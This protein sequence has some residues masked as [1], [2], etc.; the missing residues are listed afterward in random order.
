M[1]QRMQPVDPARLLEEYRTLLETAD[2]LPLRV[3][4]N[5]MAPFLVHDR[6][7]VFLTRVNRPLRRGDIVLYRRK[8][9]AYILHRICGAKGDLFSMVGDAQTRIEYGIG[10]EQIFAVVCSAL[11]KGRR[12]KPGCFWW[13]FFEKIWVRI[14]P[15]R[16]VL[17]R[18][19]GG[20]KRIIRRIE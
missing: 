6:D 2:Q 5:S 13:D 1:E 12:Q 14:I 3:S 10:R 18:T 8:T 7:T 19:Y 17:L 4:G 11:R 15:V 16:P 9:G 20:L